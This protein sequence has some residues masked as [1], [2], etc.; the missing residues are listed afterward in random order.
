MPKIYGE[1]AAIVDDGLS[2]EEKAEMASDIAAMPMEELKALG[3]AIKVSA[4]LV[5][6]EIDKRLA[7]LAPA[8]S[9]VPP[10]VFD[11]AGDASA[12][13]VSEVSSV[14]LDS[15]GKPVP[16]M[17]ASDLPV[18]PQGAL[19]PSELS[20]EG[21]SDE[22]PSQ[23]DMKTLGARITHLEVFLKSTYPGGN[24]APK[25]ETIV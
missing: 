23:M 19:T 12:S 5:G 2:D 8:A 16:P 9:N 14:T 20:P 7:E 15:D 6:K 1:L 22:P 25:F 10:V 11:G 17:D 21:A 18:P 24:G 13:T 3:E 4:A